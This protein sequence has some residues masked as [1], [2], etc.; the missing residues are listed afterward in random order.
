MCA[1]DSKKCLE[2]LGKKNVHHVGDISDWTTCNENNLY[3]KEFKYLDFLHVLYGQYGERTPRYHWA[4]QNW[5]HASHCWC[6]DL[7]QPPG[8]MKVEI[9]TSSLSEKHK[10]T[11]VSGSTRNNKAV[12][13]VHYWTNP[14]SSLLTA[15]ATRMGQRP[16]RNWCRASS[17]SLWDRSPWMLVQA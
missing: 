3:K 5:W 8:Q 9:R 7:V 12:F 2:E 13:E 11:T 6:P 10:Q 14:G 16:E 4:N 1:W 17:L 15:V